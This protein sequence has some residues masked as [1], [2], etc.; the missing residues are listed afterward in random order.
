MLIAVSTIVLI[1]IGL[2]LKFRYR[3]KVHIPLM[4]GAFLLDLVLLLYIEFSRHAIAEFQQELTTPVHGGLLFFH[5][6]VSL[7]TLIFYLIQIVTGIMLVQ[8][9]TSRRAWH[10]MVSYAFVVCRLAN[11][12]T[13]FMVVG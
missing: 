1:L 5:V 9:Q 8:G 7:L 12:V 4:M 3:P 10:R 2:G 6:G 13:S 11:Y